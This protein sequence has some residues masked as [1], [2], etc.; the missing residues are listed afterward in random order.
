MKKTLSLFLAIVMALSVF[1]GIS[2]TAFAATIEQV[3][4]NLSEPITVIENVD[5]FWD[6]YDREEY[7]YYTYYFNLEDTVKV[8]MS[9][10]SEVVYFISED[11]NNFVS[12]DGDILSYYLYDNQEEK[13]WG[14]GEHKVH[15]VV[16]DNTDLPVAQTEIP[17]IVISNPVSDVKVSV[18]KLTLVENTN[19]WWDKDENA[20]MY[21]VI[22]CFEEGDTITV[23]KTDG[24]SI[25]YVYSMIDVPEEEWSYYAFVDEDG[26]ELTLANNIDYQCANP[27]TVGMNT[28]VLELGEYGVTIEVPV[29]ILKGSQET[30]WHEFSEWKQVNGLFQQECLIGCG[31]VTKLPFIDLSG[32]DYYADFIAYT[33]VYNQFLKGT[34]PP[35]FTTFS[36]KTSITRAMIITILYRMAG[37]PENPYDTNPFTD[38]TDT[39]AYYYD[40]ACWALKNGITTEANFRPFDNVTREQTACFLFRYAE[41]NDLLGDPDYKSVNLRTEYLDSSLIH[42]WAVEAMKWANYNGMITGTKQGYANPQGATQ[43]IHATKILF[44]FGYLCD[45]GNL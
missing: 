39:N 19:G 36:P 40:A 15:F 43:R 41:L 1:S 20:Y 21:D 11:E 33:S 6:E 16:C 4:Y 28:A 38:I 26:N 18:D 7:F 45:I 9:D 23:N 5:G 35:A 17:V 30:C 37:E 12:E 34:N 3:E 8:T 44:G 27:F 2:F 10:G 14:L 31:E 13:H 25:V 32:Y 24:T 29:E 22:D 42:N